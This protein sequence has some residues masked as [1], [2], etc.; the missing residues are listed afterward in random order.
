MKVN[1]QIRWRFTRAVGSCRGF[2][3][4]SLRRRWGTDMLNESEVVQVERYSSSGS[5]T[6]WLRRSRLCKLEVTRKLPVIEIFFGM[7]RTAAP[8]SCASHFSLY[9]SQS[10]VPIHSLKASR[11]LLLIFSS[12]SCSFYIRHGRHKIF[13]Q[14]AS[15]KQQPPVTDSFTRCAHKEWLSH[16]EAAYVIR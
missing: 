12:I 15:T 16:T 6:W 10:R 8:G 3:R 13:K 5:R 9:D 11:I 14:R 1:F 4:M 2:D 7:M